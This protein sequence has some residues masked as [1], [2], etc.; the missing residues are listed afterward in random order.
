MN[1]C[2]ELYIDG[3]FKMAPKK[4]YQILNIW[5]FLKTKKIY[6]PL[7][8]IIMTSKNYIAYTHVFNSIKNLL[9]DNNIKNNF[10]NKSITTDYE[11]SLRR[12]INDILKP[13]YINGCYFHFSKCLW[14]KSSDYG[15]MV[16]NFIK[17]V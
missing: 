10:S 8:H 3:T 4:F 7:I 17:I 1:E 2:E 11:K 6:L 16:K 5:G 13:K 14:K 12:A 15:L 9:T